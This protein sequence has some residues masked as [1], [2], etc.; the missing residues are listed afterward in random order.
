MRYQA[1]NQFARIAI[2]E[3]VRPRR[4]LHHGEKIVDVVCN[5]AR[6]RQYA[7]QTPFVISDGEFA[8]GTG[9]PADY[10]DDVATPDADHFAAHQPHPGKDEY[11][12]MVR[13][14]VVL[15][16]VLVLTKGRA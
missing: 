11:V 13:G 1:L 15:C 3:N 5:P 9:A 16:D 2:V 12:N 7:N 6:P 4:F 14:T 8:Q 10:D